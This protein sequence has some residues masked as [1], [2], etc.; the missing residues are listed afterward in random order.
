MARVSHLCL[1]LAQQDFR[2]S[3][4]SPAPKPALGKA[5]PSGA[6]PV[7]LNVISALPCDLHLDSPGDRE[8]E[9]GQGWGRRQGWGHGTQDDG[10]PIGV[11][12][13]EGWNCSGPG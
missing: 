3:L 10:M 6:R 11:T 5:V 4:A 12:S 2:S 8:Q 9:V 1:H 13:A 7:D